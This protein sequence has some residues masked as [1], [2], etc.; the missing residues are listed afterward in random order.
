MVQRHSKPH[1]SRLAVEW[2]GEF[3]GGVPRVWA[4]IHDAAFR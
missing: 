4:L 2:C 3:G 1:L